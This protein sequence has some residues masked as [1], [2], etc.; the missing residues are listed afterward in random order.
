[1]P[2]LIFDLDGTLVDSAALIT[3]HLAGALRAV[4]AEVPEPAGL[5]RLVGPPFETALPAIG[6]TAEQTT[7]LEPNAK[8]VAANLP[9]IPT[10][11]ASQWFQYNSQNYVGWPTPD[12]PYQTGQPSGNNNGP[13][14]GTNEVVLLHL[15]PRA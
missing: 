10:T 14:S 8:Y 5:M 3:E 2:A 9:I 12:N 1:M 15:R 13:G 4:G 7:A 11:T 6:L